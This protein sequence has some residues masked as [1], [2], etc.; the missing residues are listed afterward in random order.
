M[1]VDFVRRKGGGSDELT[2][3]CVVRD[4]EIMRNFFRDRLLIRSIADAAGSLET[5]LRLGRHG[6]REP[7]EPS[8]AFGMTR[9]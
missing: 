4:L 3:Q 9:T 6:R 7:S 5:A 1:Y 2:A 8:P